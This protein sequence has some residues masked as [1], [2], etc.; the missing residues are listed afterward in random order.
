[1]I[2]ATS[3]PFWWSW[4]L[5]GLGC[6]GIWKAGDKSPTGWAI[7]LGTECLW[8]A[9]AVTTGQWGFIVGCGLYAGICARNLMKWWK[10]RLVSA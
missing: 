4:L 8:L 9:Y 5:S 3:I 10:A 6:V 1:M 7:T 2:F